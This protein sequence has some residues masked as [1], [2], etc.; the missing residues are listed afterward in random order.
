M[1]GISEYCAV[2]VHRSLS[3]KNWKKKNY[4]G[5]LSK[6]LLVR[7]NRETQSLIL[8]GLI[9]SQDAMVG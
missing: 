3:I 8:L 6:A 1:G 7:S 9:Q 2:C 4:T 5:H